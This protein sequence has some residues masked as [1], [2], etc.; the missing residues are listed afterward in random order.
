MNRRPPPRRPQPNRPAKPAP[1]RKPAPAEPPTHRCEADV[2]EGLE[3]VT[4]DE[5]LERFGERVELV[6]EGERKPGMLRFDYVGNLYQLTKLQSVQAVYLSRTFPVPR[7]KAL[8]GDQHFKA[9]LG[10]IAAVRELSPADAYQ[11]FYISAAGSESSVMTRLKEELAAKTG[12]KPAFEEGDLLIRIRRPIDEDDGWEVLMRLSPRPLAT[13]PWR[14]CNREGALNAV[15]ARA[16]VLLTMPTPEDVFLNVACGSG[17]LL[18]ERAACG[19]AQGLTGYDLDEAAL[20]CAARNIEAAGFSERIKLNLGDATDLPLPGK[21]VDVL[22]ADLPF[23]H[24]IGSHDENKALYPALLREAARVAK[25]G[26]RFALIT[27]EVHLL[28]NLLEDSAD[29]E[30][31]QTIRVAL[32]GLYPRVFLLRRK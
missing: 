13:R 19:P 5:L 7:P 18:I 3:W 17:T 15:V 1:S 16:M 29:W 20:Q 11:T 22:C 23:G 30:A 25:P 8:L 6:S 14:V 21:S 31:I 28:E 4:R 27:H 24:L 10:M 2:P 9:L 12:L 32:G 26:A